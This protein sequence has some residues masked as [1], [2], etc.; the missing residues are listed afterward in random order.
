VVAGISVPLL[1][2]WRRNV[3]LRAPVTT[4]ADVTDEDRAALRRYSKRMVLAF[5][6]F[7]PIALSLVSIGAVPPV[8]VGAQTATL[9]TVGV[10]VAIL[11][12]AHLKT[13]CPACGYRLGY[14]Q[15]LG[16]GM[17]RRLLKF[18]GGSVDD[19]A[20]FSASCFTSPSC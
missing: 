3:A 16:V 6:L 2:L 12:A 13:R 17:S 7:W 15:S 4:T 5:I 9:L 11:I 19:Y 14:Q 8:S 1:V 10:L 20:T 18:G